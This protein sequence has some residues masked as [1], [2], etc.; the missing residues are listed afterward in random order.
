MS[1]GK[2]IALVTGAN[3]GIGK[4][5]T[6]GLARDGWV[7]LA[8]VRDGSSVSHLAEESGIASEQIVAI[9]MDISEPT[10]VTRGVARL[11]NLVPKVDLLINNA[12]Q[13]T[14][15]TLSASLQALESLL[16]VNLVGPFQ[17]LKEMQPLLPQGSHIINISSIAGTNGYADLGAYCASKFGMVG[18]SECLAR[19]FVDSGIKVTTI[20]P[21]WVDTAMAKALG[22]NLRSDEMIRPADLILTVRWLLSLSPAAC[23]RQL[24]IECPEDLRG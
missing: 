2:K 3:R 21:S 8:V 11:L 10:S 13:A 20:C 4:A 7:V 15:G 24:T 14:P 17:L 16:K 22:A 6:V 12:G 18:L 23:V 9:E 1:D 5:L 19:D